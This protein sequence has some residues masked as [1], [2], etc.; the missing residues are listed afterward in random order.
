MDTSQNPEFSGTVRNWL[1]NC[2]YADIR[3]LCEAVAEPGLADK[4]RQKNHKEVSLAM[5]RIYNRM[6]REAQ[7]EYLWIVEDD[8]LPPDNACERLLQRFDADTASVS[9]AYWSR[10]AHGY[11][12][13]RH[14]RSRIREKG[15]GVQQVGGN[16]FGCVILRRSVLRD[17]LFT[18]TLDIPAYDN[19]F[20]H[21]LAATRFK[22]KLDWSVQCDHPRRTKDARHS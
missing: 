2:D 19:A 14:D 16:G 12:A 18:A 11:V 7:T 17:T 3:H 5:A 21:R 8:N 10:F 15:F 13:W 22:A 1:A 9:A 6:Q 20:Y 4:P